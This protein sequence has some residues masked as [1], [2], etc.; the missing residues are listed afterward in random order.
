MIKKIL[1]GIV[2]VIVVLLI[3]GFVLP[4]KFEIT[5]TAQ[6][7]AP[8]DYVFEEVN[9][10]QK[11]TNWSYW[12]S[13]DPKT[14]MKYGEKKSGIGASYEWK[15]EKTGEGKLMVTESTPS[16]SVAADLFFMEAEE[17]AKAWYKFEPNEQGTNVTMGFSTDFGMNPIMRWMGVIMFS[18]EMEKAFDYNLKKLKEVAEGKPKFSV[19]IT[20]EETVPINYIG[21]S[22]TMGYE[23]EKAIAA[24]MGKS[25]GELASVLAKARVDMTGPAFALYPMW[26]EAT[27]QMEMVCAFPVSAD[28]KLPPKYKVMQTSGGKAIKGI[29]T[30][31]FGKMMATHEEIM[32]YISLKKLEINGAPSEVYITDPMAEKDTTKWV[33]EIY[34]PVKN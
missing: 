30:G 33:T 23:D 5:R 16:A 15:S 7:N 32:K 10:L 12:Y 2:G 13:L 19:A 27:K 18:S 21:I 3:I 11:W 8:A 31:D 24:Q 4:Q 29:H 20:E 34:Y 22:T 25:F 1:L 9:D 28:A 26:D 6:V 17:P 14:E